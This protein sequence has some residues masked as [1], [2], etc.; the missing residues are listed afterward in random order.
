MTPQTELNQVTTAV[1]E[2]RRALAEGSF[3][4]LAGLE[5]AVARICAAASEVSQGERPLFAERL[6]ALADALDLL[7]A[8][9]A[10]LGATAQRRRAADA[11]GDGA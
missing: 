10:R 9:I 2:A 1:T 3:V 8:D 6:T 4:D 7:A 5:S 11:Y